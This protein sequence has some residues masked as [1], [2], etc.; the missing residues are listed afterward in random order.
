MVESA[1]TI[2]NAG[3]ALN[4]IA[5][6]NAVSQLMCNALKTQNGMANPANVLQVST[7]LV[8]DALGVSL[9]INLTVLT[10]L[11][12]NNLLHVK[13]L[14]Q[15]LQE[16]SVFVDLILMNSKEIVFNARILQCGM[17]YFV[18]EIMMLV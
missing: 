13:T 16:E 3:Q 2:K 10:V 5:K 11:E 12:F 18:K 7:L 17:D 8:K 4:G 15:L 14:T 9:A 1:H 6:A